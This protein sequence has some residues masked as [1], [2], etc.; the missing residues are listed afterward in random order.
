MNQV[1]PS[2]W[3]IRLWGRKCELTY[4][5]ARSCGPSIGWLT[6]FF[7][8]VG[9]M[10]SNYWEYATLRLCLPSGTSSLLIQ[11]RT[12]SIDDSHTESVRSGFFDAMKKYI[13]KWVP[14]WVAHRSKY[15]THTLRKYRLWTLKTLRISSAKVDII[16]VSQHILLF[17]SS[18]WSCTMASANIYRTPF[19]HPDETRGP[20]FLAVSWTTVSL[21]AILV[22]LRVFVRCKTHANGWDDYL[23][24]FALVSGLIL[25]MSRRKVM[26]LT[27]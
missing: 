27:S 18:L 14:R 25:H 19:H 17:T 24:Y 2:T 9:R 20:M 11:L 26:S 16:F 12:A 21:A 8:L 7:S 5:D 1:K 15:Q 22:A 3:Q 10:Y 23:I 13:E 6:I 4:T